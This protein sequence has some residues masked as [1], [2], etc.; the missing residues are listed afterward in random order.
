MK[1]RQLIQSLQFIWYGALVLL[2]VTLFSAS[3]INSDAISKITIQLK[4]GVTEHKD[5]RIPLIQ[6]KEES[7]PDYTISYRTNGHWNTVGTKLNTSALRPIKFHVNDGPNIHLT[8]SI[9]ISDKDLAE[10]DH[11]EQFQLNGLFYEGDTFIMKIETIKSFKSGLS[12]FA[13]TSIGQAVLA[14]IFLAVFF[15]VISHIEIPV[16]C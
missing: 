6:K 10:H 12:W 1:I 13:S 2:V 5:K 8:R 9:R 14:G 7:L 16:P 3:Y 15:A 4:P 11:L